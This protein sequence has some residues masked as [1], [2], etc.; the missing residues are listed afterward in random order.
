MNLKYSIIIPTLNEEKL[1]PGLLGSLCKPVLKSKFDYEVIV[2]DGGSTDRTLEIARQHCDKVVRY[3]KGEVR[4]ISACRSKGAKSASGENLLFI[5]A[6]VT[7]DVERLLTTA[8]MKF[9]SD[10]Y[11]AMTCPIKCVPEQEKLSDKCFS[12]VC[13]VYYY[14]SNL[15]GL[16]MARGEFQVIRR[17]VYEN[18]GGYREELITGE[19]FDLFTRIR[20]HGRIL[21]TWA[22]TVY[23]SPRRYRAWGY[24]RTISAWL[25]SS[26]P[27]IKLKRFYKNWE[28][29]R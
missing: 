24:R 11:V 21:F 13:N 26:L 8:E 10:G 9:A 22:V 6:D 25:L 5:N 17:K 28:A 14:F 27:L 12:A 23:E 3:E 18:V 2:S 16:G 4:S 1:L 19:D 7:F 29:I 20:K 15:A